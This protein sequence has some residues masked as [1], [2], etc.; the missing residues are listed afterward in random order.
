PLTDDIDGIRLEAPH[1]E[2]LPERGF[3]S[4][5]EGFV[6]PPEDGADVEVVVDP[7]SERLQVLQPFPAWDGNDLVELPVL[8][9]AAG[10][11]TTDHISAAGPWLRYRGHLENICGNLFLGVVN[12]FTGDAGTGRSIVDGEKRPYPDIARQA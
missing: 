2:T 10:K 1:G 12:A 9:K 5:T 3:E 7:T 11:C 8:L 4:G 6:A